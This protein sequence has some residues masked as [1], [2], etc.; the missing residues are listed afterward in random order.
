MSKGLSQ[1]GYPTFRSNALTAAIAT[2]NGVSL[3]NRQ[4]IL[5][6]TIIEIQQPPAL[7][8]SKTVTLVMDGGDNT[9]ITIPLPLDAL[10][11]ER[12]RRMELRDSGRRI[13]MRRARTIRNNTPKD[14][15]DESVLFTSGIAAKVVTTFSRVSGKTIIMGPGRPPTE[16]ELMLSRIEQSLASGTAST[17]TSSGDK[18][19]TL[20]TLYQEIKVLELEVKAMSHEIISLSLSRNRDSRQLA[21]VKQ[22]HEA[23]LK[24]LDAKKIQLE[25]LLQQ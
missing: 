18:R 12:T 10:T 15:V 9:K 24:V 13:V 20:E 21:A 19:S 5:E 17:A 16:D 1:D 6:G 23:K 11:A 7:S 2:D 25:T 14:W 22:T 4:I 3:Q 8:N